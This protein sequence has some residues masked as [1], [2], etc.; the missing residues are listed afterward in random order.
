MSQSL[1]LFATCPKG[2]ED[3]LAEECNRVRCDVHLRREVLQ[4]NAELE[5]HVIV[6]HGETPS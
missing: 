6:R 5:T 2:V 4:I 3:L 1:T